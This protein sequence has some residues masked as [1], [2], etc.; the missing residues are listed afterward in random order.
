MVTSRCIT[1]YRTGRLGF[2]TK[3]VLVNAIIMREVI[4]SAAE[5]KIGILFHN[6]KD[7]VSLRTTLE[8]LGHEKGPTP[9]Q[10][11]NNT[12]SGFATDK[13]KQRCSKAVDMRFHW[14]CDRTGQ[15][16]FLIC[17]APVNKTWPITSP[18]IIP[19]ATIASCAPSA[20]T[21]P[22][23]L[24]SCEGVLILSPGASTT[25]RVLTS[26]GHQNAEF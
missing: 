15:G 16:Q 9:M 21:S 3:P 18:S 24:P 10:T 7:A 4:S 19:P 8:E 6:G 11:D 14:V 25:R 2:A 1:F 26:A 22:R 23:A 20:F 12:A 17:W 5:C 13:I